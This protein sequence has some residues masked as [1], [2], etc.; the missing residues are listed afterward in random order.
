MQRAAAE[1][2]LADA[3][4]DAPALLGAPVKLVTLYFPQHLL[5]GLHTIRIL[6]VQVF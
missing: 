5:H 2:L 1:F 4:H 6:R 3:K